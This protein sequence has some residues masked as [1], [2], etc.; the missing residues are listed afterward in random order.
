MKTVLLAGGHGTR[1]AEETH[2]R[3]KPM[4]EIG[5]MPI[6]VHIMRTYSAYGYR[7]FVVAG[8]YKADHIKEYFS[9]FH[10]RNSDWKID[11]RTGERTLFHAAV[12][13]WTVSIVDTGLHTMTGGRIQRLRNVVGD[14]P[15]MVTYGDGVADLS[16]C[17]LV[18]FH[19][20]HGRLATVTAVH[21]PARFG[22]LDIR[23]NRVHCF[24][25][26]P[27]TSA[28]WI[29][30][31]YFVFEPG[32]FD[33]LDGDEC[34]LEKGPLERLTSDGQLMAFCH[35]GFWQPMDTL[36]EKQLL[37]ELWHTNRAPWKVE[38][39]QDAQL[40]LLPW[41]ASACHRADGL[42]GPVARKV[43]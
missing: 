43:A 37:E 11:L 25:E 19:R 15:F 8:G 17:D 6:L 23:E 1:L 38:H 22:C 12:P 35:E 18:A 33:Y 7:E 31:G 5:G 42:Q 28:G 21:P 10:I 34:V 27:Q 14:E 4:V 24:A 30:G 40:G 13:P 32:V 39:E 20:A 29:N 9:N 36:R 41:S 16:I 3:P 26:K 2:L